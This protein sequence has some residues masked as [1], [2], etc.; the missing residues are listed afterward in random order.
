[1]S[2]VPH[3]DVIQWASGHFLTETY[4]PDHPD[5]SEEDIDAFIEQ[6]LSEDYETYEASEVHR[7][8]FDLA[9]DVLLGMDSRLR[10]EWE[11]ISNE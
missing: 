11:Y 6:H 3:P 4:P 1:M 8:I 9:Y 2:K 5:M 10:F 7:M